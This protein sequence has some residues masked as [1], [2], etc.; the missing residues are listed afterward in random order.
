M[1]FCTS[2]PAATVLWVPHLELNP[3]TQLSAWLVIQTQAQALTGIETKQDAFE[4]RPQRRQPVPSGSSLQVLG[5]QR[6][7][8]HVAAL[9]L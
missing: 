5:P 1:A 3:S 7:V 6:E 9:M 4:P 2:V 8:C